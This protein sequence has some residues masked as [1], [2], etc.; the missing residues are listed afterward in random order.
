MKPNRWITLSRWVYARLLNLYPREHGGEYGPSMLQLFTDQ[1]RSAYGERGVWGLV[2]LWPRTLIDLSANSLREH[3]ASP[4]LTWGLLEAVPNEPLPWKGVL[5]VIIPGLIFFVGQIAQLSGEDWFFL[6][7]Y[8][9]AYMLIIPVVLIGL[10]T[11]KVP[12]WGLVPIGLLYSTIWWV[13]YRFERGAVNYSVPILSKVMRLISPYDIGTREAAVCVGILI[14]LILLVGWIMRRRYI[15]RRLWIW[16]GVYALLTVTHALHRVFDTLQNSGLS[17]FRMQG[18]L[19]R[20][21]Y[22]DFH[23]YGGF[24]LLILFGALLARRHGRLA[25][26]VPLGSMLPTV[27][28]GRFSAEWETPQFMFWISTGALIFRL[29]VA[30]VAPIWILRTTP[31]EPQ[32]RAVAISLLSALAIGVILDV[33]M[34]GL[35]GVLSAYD[36]IYD[37]MDLL[38]LSAGVFLALDLYQAAAQ[39]GAEDRSMALVS[40][41]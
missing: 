8:R 34:Y 1:C 13:I 16:M 14:G 11:R 12:I 25:I 10:F 24:L 30:L 20:L 29:L 37:V 27:L 40:S 28:F 6:L 21:W 17:E 15:I 2:V 19:P 23:T 22:W 5:L 26:L 38:I 18:Y 41:T 36:V 31:G 35:R 39:T 3:L 7:S 33:G 9:A 32:R 4:R